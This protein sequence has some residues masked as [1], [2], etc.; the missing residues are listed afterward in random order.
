MLVIKYKFKTAIAIWG[1]RVAGI[2]RSLIWSKSLMEVIFNPCGEFQWSPECP[3]SQIHSPHLHVGAYGIFSDLLRSVQMLKREWGAESNGTLPRLFIPSKTANL[4]P[5]FAVESMPL[6][7][8]AALVPNFQ[9]KTCPWAEHSDDCY[10]DPIT[11]RQPYLIW[12]TVSFF[13]S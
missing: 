6:D 13:W 2:F 11:Y 9:W 12:N 10:I 7:R 5:E 8:I 3:V 1:R 4:V